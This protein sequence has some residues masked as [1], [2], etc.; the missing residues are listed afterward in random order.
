VAARSNSAAAD[1]LMTSSISA[2]WTGRHAMTSQSRDQ[3]SGGAWRAWVLWISC[4]PVS[5][6]VLLFT[7]AD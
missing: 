1:R 6:A 2:L 5:T 4:L 7:K 3:I